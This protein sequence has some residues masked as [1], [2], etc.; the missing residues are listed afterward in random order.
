LLM[1]MIPLLNFLAMP[2]AVAGAT[3]MWVGE[4]R[5][6]SQTQPAG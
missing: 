5:S 6:G 4:F 1:T 2:V 3:A